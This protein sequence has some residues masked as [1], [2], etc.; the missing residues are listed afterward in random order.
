MSGD[1]LRAKIEALHE[2]HVGGESRHGALAW[3][4][5][6]CKRTGRSVYTWTTM[7]RVPDGPH[8]VALALLEVC[9]PASRTLREVRA[10][11]DK[12]AEE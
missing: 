3:F 8:L 4:G 11:L 6:W 10:A 2:K 7:A 5:R 9:S 12:P 1:E